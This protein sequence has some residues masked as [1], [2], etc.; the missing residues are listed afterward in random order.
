MSSI[1]LMM[2][3]S[4]AQ[5]S[6]TCVAAAS[7]MTEFIILEAKGTRHEQQISEAIRKKGGKDKAVA[8]LASGMDEDKCAFILAAPDSTIRALAISTLP[9]RT[10]N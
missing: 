4:M 2:F 10:G 6:P 9:E 8:A 3:L 7:R 1:A 5:A